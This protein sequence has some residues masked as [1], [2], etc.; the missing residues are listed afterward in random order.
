MV[1]TIDENGKLELT[2][3]PVGFLSPAGYFKIFTNSNMAL[4]REYIM[5]KRRDEVLLNILFSEN[6]PFENS[7]DKIRARHRTCLFSKKTQLT[8]D[9]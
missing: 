1:F 4:F 3:R 8:K 6:V 9:Y 7:F 2:K 5:Q